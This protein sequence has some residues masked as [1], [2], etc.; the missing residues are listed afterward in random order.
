M[1][2][3]FVGVDS[4]SDWVN[5]AP[6]VRRRIITDGQ[7]VMLVEFDFETGAVGALHHHPHEQIS[8]VLRGRAHYTVGGETREVQAGDTVHIPS[9]VEHGLTALD[10]CTLL[11]VFSPPRE[12]FRA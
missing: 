11:D 3:F 7:A 8:Y 9:N 2:N 10:A 5:T 1:L 4:M 6:G 12:D